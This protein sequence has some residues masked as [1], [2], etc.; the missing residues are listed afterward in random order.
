MD[1]DSLRRVV[2]L[3]LLVAVISSILTFHH[4]GENSLFGDEA[5]V[6]TIARRA[7]VNGEW[8]PLH[9]ATP[10]YVSKP[11]LSIWPMALRFEVG[12]ASELNVRI[13][14]AIGGV[15]V[16]LLLF[17]LGTW[18]LDSTAGAIAALL[19][20]TA[21]PWLLNHGVRE[22]VGDVWSALFTGVALLAYAQGRIANSRKL[23]FIAVG[24]AIAGSLIKGP[25]V[26]LVLFS[27]GL[28]WELTARALHDRRPRVLLLTGVVLASAIPLALWIVDSAARDPTARTKLWAQFVGRHTQALDPTHLHDIW[29]YPVVLAQAFGW[30]LLALLLPPLWRW[31]RARELALLLPLW[32][33]LPIVVFSLSVSKLPWYID[34]ILPAL[35][36]LLGIAASLGIAQVRIATL[37]YLLTALVVA[38]LGVRLFASWRGVHASPRQTEM[39]R[40][41]LA[42]R[43]ADHPALYV[44]KLGATS[45]G[46]RE[47]NAYY[48]NLLP[49][50]AAAVPPAIDRSRCTLVV[51]MKPE[52]LLRRADFAGA[53]MQQLHKYDPRED[54][55]YLIDLCGGRFVRALAAP[56]PSS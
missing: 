1:Q 44:D 30:W 41:V 29:F 32:A 55:L 38:A 11:P 56:Q 52:P 12:G 6:A 23:L 51:T 49:R 27:V 21:P 20:I 5:I 46:Y 7:V 33:F 9:Y 15:L 48:L 14:S 3:A 18:L 4:L 31:L 26:L 42:F 37:R 8:Y 2:I 19:L 40:T 13:G 36:T 50:A 43:S 35:A 22:G 25:V 53:A 54:D 39:H 10:V 17:A 24:A 28:L 47:W 34:P 45:F 16:S